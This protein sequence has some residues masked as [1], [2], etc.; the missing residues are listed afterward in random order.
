MQLLEVGDVLYV[1]LK[2]YYSEEC[3]RTG[4]GMVV[5]LDPI[6]DGGAHK[7]ATFLIKKETQVGTI[8]HRV[9]Q[10]KWYNI[11]HV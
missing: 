9:Q 5:P 4:L 3:T 8:I 1:A 6:Q 2:P 11:I 10:I 7:A